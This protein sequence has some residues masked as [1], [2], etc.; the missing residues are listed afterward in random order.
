MDPSITYYSIKEAK[1]VTHSAN[2]HKSDFDLDIT[3]SRLKGLDSVPLEDVP[4]GFMGSLSGKRMDVKVTFDDPNSV[5]C[6]ARIKTK[7]D[8]RSIQK[9]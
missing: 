8:P 4:K 6:K 1:I 5:A 9:P 3:L 7:Q 2:E